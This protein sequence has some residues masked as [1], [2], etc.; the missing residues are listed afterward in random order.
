MPD[1]TPFERAA[2]VGLPAPGVARAPSARF[3][4]SRIPGVAYT[5]A[6]LCL[7]FA[8]TSKGFLDPA[9]LA[10]I[11][12]QST[13]LLMLA[14]PMTLIILTE[15]IDLSLGAVLT[16][17]SVVLA[18]TVVGTGSAALGLC[19]ALALGA[20]FGFANGALTAWVGI[21]PFVVTLG[22]MGIAQG[23]ALIVTD[24]QSI[25]GMPVTV[26]WWYG[27][28]IAGVPVPIAVA[29]LFYLACHALLYHTRFGTYVFALGGNPEALRL[30]GVRAD[31]YL[32]GVYVLGGLASGF[33]ALMLTAR[34]SAGHPTAA[35]GLE[36]EAIAAVALG[37]TSFEKGNG[38]LFGTVLGVLAVGVLRNGLNLL[39]TQSAVQV[40]AIGVLV[41]GALLVDNLRSRR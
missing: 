41:I 5:L 39:G 27:G 16:V 29:V 20:V 1:P 24:A 37:G 32:V 35:I 31:L 25:V 40:A 8:V 12:M 2:A 36:F 33:A 19:A 21:P 7:I 14:L 6:A 3:E 30:A 34:M 18:A 13:I 23:L 38:W 17:A 26:T 10:N 11:G 15:G 22:T 9:N 4:W 28:F